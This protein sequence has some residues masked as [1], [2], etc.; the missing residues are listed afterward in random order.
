MQSFLGSLNYYSRF[1]EDYEVYAVV[2][3]ELREV[4]FAAMAKDSNR[5]QIERSFRRSD[6]D[7]D[8]GAQNLEPQDAGASDMYEIDQR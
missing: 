1:I 2:L 7:Q 4:D 5:E 3:Y 6:L 8:L